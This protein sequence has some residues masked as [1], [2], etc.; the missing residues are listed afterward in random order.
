MNKKR[1][2]LVFPGGTEIGLEIWKS[3][4]Y[5]KEVRLFSAGLDVPNH[6]PFVFKYHKTLPSIFEKNWIEELNKLIER[7]HIEYIF[8]AYD[9]IIVALKENEEKI[10]AKIITSP[11]ETVRITRSK[12]KT[13]EFLKSVV[14]VPKVYSSSDKRLSFPVFVKPEKGQGTQDSRIVNN[15][16]QLSRLLKEYP[17]LM[18]L[19]FLP[20]KEYTVDCFSDRDKGLMF[21]S[22]R[23]RIRT[24]A[25]ISMTSEIVKNDIFRIYAEK[26]SSKLKFYGAWFFQLKENRDGVLTLLEIAPR[27]AGTMATNRVLGVNFALL[28]IYEADRV[29]ISIM[30]NNYQV[31]ID[32]AL[33]NRYQTNLKYK[34]VY[35]DL[36]DQLIFRK[37]VNI[38]LLGFLYQCFNKNIELIL[39][40]KHP[41]KLEEYMNQHAISPRLFSKIIQLKKHEEKFKYVQSKNAIFIDDS[42]S[43]R[44]KVAEKCG[45]PTFDC[46]MLELLIDERI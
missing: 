28:S 13:Y 36:D 27:I 41:G 33:V 46:S 44:K 5:C 39:L 43:E 2:V 37:K 40:T 32:R 45:I 4:R 31:K 25:G 35:V 6:A 24:R 1:N 38:F 16:E 10:K 11:L 22:G 29:D 8:P 18:I 3:L 12:K 21:C 7:H 19:E 17:N 26:I 20:G 42:F 30:V 15:R 34:V 9:D 14:P 23:E